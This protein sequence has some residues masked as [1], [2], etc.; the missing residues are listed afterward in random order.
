MTLAI[1]Q[2]YSYLLI[3]TTKV[4][5]VFYKFTESITQVY[6]HFMDILLYF[7]VFLKRIL[8]IPRFDIIK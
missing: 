2:I 7:N 4:F 6:F 8:D 5:Q 3:F 1:Q